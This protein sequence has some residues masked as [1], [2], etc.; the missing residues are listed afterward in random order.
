MIKIKDFLAKVSNTDKLLDRQT[1]IFLLCVLLLVLRIPNLFEP[2]WYGD[3]GIYLTIGQSINKGAKLYSEIIDH[4]TPLIYYLA[5]VQTQLNFRLL[6]IGWMLLTTI[7]F[8]YFAKKL[9]K[10][11]KQTTFATFIFVILT[12]LPWLEG[13]IPNGELFVLGFVMWGAIIIAKTEYFKKFLNPE[14]ITLKT[15]RSEIINIVCLLSAGF[16][17]GLGILTKV[18]AILDLAVF[19]SIGYFSFTNKILNETNLVK[20]N[21]KNNFENFKT[22]FGQ[23][24]TLGIGVIIPIIISIIYFVSIGSGQAYL[25]FGLLYNF[26]YA[27]SWQLPFESN[28]LQFLFTLQGKFLIVVAVILFLTFFKKHFKPAAQFIMSWFVLSLF[29]SLLSNRPYPHYFI[30]VV[31]P[32]ALLIT[33]IL[34][35]KYQLIRNFKNSSKTLLANIFAQT[36]LVLLAISVMVL[37]NFSPYQT[38][39]YYINWYKLVTNQISNDEYRQSFDYLMTDN[40]KAAEI[41]TSSGSKDLFIWGTNPML[42]ALTQTQP[43]GRFTVSFHIKDFDAFGETAR[44]VIKKKPMFIVVMK[45]ENHQFLEFKSFLNQNYLPNRS[46]FDN[47]T[48]WKRN[49]DSFSE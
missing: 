42:Y 21:F 45:N 33:L 35:N 18:P 11:V 28:L 47:F 37:L 25:D 41:I 40:Y 38:N 31:P 23:L 5:T 4:K 10:S 12:T 32:F 6:N 19:L 24:F 34:K 26:R 36:F 46:Q 2:Y 14:L 22:I 27:A 20:G 30:Q 49:N 39:K 29:A 3:E 8:Y 48:L 43:T 15:K 7:A 13:N 44:D 16:L 9:L 1:P 17:F